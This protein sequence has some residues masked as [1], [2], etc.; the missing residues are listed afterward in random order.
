MGYGGIDLPAA[1]ASYDPAIGLTIRLPVGLYDGAGTKP[2]E[3]TIT[4]NQAT[5]T[6][7]LR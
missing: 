3:V 6:V 4:I 7:T 2:A 5:G 1:T